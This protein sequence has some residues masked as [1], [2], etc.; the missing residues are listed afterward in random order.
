MP[1]KYKPD[2]LSTREIYHVLRRSKNNNNA[3]KR[4]K[5]P[6]IVIKMLVPLGRKDLHFFQFKYL[7]NRFQ[8]VCVFFLFSLSLADVRVRANSVMR[9]VMGDLIDVLS[10]SLHPTYNH[11]ILDNNLAILQVGKTTLM[12]TTFM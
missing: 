5:F 1:L 6:F 3:S 8:V 10:Y 4:N 11:E 12:V 7:F 9:G 2:R